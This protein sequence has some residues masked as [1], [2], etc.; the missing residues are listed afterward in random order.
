MIAILD[1]HYQGDTAYAAAVVAD[2]W[3][4]AKPT[5]AKVMRVDHVAAYEPGNFYKRELPCLLAVLLILPA[6]E[7]LMIDGN[8]W[9]DEDKPGLGAHLYE[10]MNRVVPVIGVAK[11]SY[12]GSA[13]ASR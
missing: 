6:M 9:L 3:I 5:L 4:V 1:V 8:V 10:T 7:H 12:R 13:N 11:T 2:N